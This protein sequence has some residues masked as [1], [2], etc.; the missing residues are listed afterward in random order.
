MPLPTLPDH[1]LTLAFSDAAGSEDRGWHAHFEHLQQQEALE[2]L[3][4]AVAN[5][6]SCHAAAPTASVSQN[7]LSSA[8][9]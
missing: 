6:A 8:P 1:W 7:D 4:A 9:P 3:E 2:A 5:V